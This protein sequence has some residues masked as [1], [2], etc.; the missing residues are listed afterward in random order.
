MNTNHYSNT[1]KDRLVK[2]ESSESKID[3]IVINWS[4]S[5]FFGG[6]SLIFDMQALHQTYGHR[7]WDLS[8]PQ[9]TAKNKRIN[10]G[11]P[12]F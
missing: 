4:L 11:Q 1:P 6:V 7:V 9:K 5:I 12:T 2:S 8:E 3:K 10:M